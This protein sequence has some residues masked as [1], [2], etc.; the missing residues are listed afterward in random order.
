MESLLGGISRNA[1]GI[2]FAFAF[3]ESIGF[4]VP[5]ALALLIAGAAAANG[6]VVL[7]IAAGAAWLGTMFGDLFL[8]FLGR[9]TGWWLLEIL[10]R[11]SLNPEACIVRAAGSFHK[12]GRWLLLFA[13]FVPGINTMAPPL[14]GSMNM[15]FSQFL[16]LD[17]AGAFLYIN[18]WLL[19][20][21]AFKDALSAIIRGYHTFGRVMAWIAIALVV[22]YLVVMIWRW[23]K[24]RILH[25]VPSASPEDAAREQAAGAGVI[26]DVRSH[27]YYDRNAVRVKG[28]IRLDP[29]APHRWTEEIDLGRPIFLYCT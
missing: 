7:G 25:L 21:F 1:Y 15:R 18:A 14:A 8:F 17:L 3:V 2:L 20:G 26:Y 23:R 16:A 9:R 13:K 11:I 5:A 22:G 10:C 29:N 28:S 6:S 19:L 27:G 12:R 4:P 24:S